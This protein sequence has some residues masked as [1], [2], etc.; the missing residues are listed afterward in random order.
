VP[1]GAG[2]A[3]PP[4]RAPPG[5]AGPGRETAVRASAWLADPRRHGRRQARG[6]P[7]APVRAR[8]ARA[9]YRARPVPGRARAGNRRPTVRAP[10]TST[11]RAV[12]GEVRGG[13][14]C[15][16]AGGRLARPP[17][18]AESR[19][20]IARGRAPFTAAAASVAALGAARGRCP[21]PKRRAAWAGGGPGGEPGGGTRPRG[22]PP[23]GHAWPKGV[24]G[25]GARASAR[26]PG[27]YPH[28]P[29]HRSARR[30]GKHPAAVAGARRVLVVAS[31][32][33]TTGRPYAERGADASDR[34]EAAR[35]ARQHGKRL[36]QRGDAGS[37][38][39]QA[40]ALGT[41]KPGFSGE[42]V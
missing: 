36:P 42:P 24:P 2:R 12:A 34:R 22:T 20:A 3:L 9:R 40:A 5:G 17:S 16:G 7:P 21:A 31:H 25:A 10:A 6:I 4:G 23:A 38:P 8:R 19:R 32:P 33:R 27:A 14:R 18:R 39:P 15:R 13:G 29:H 11:L 35:I 41:L 37:L 30:R 26:S 28:A 1:A